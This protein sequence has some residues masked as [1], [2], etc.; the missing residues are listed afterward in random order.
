MV[1]V[2]H[3]VDRAYYSPTQDI[4]G[5]PERECFQSQD[6]YYST[7][8]HETVHSTGH[9]DRLSRRIGNNGL[10]DYSK[11][12]LVAE[13]GAAFLCGT[14]GIVT[15]V[16]NNAAYIASWLR[17]LRNDSKMVVA[18]ASQAQKACDYILNIH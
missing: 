2:K 10:T 11:E 15:T 14:A 3:G 7:L 12:E 4:I 16:D 9:E 8:F 13:I 1:P 5:M 6:E 17:V 18:A